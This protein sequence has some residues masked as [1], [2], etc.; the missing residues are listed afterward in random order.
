MIAFSGKSTHAV[1]ERPAEAH[2]VPIRILVVEDH[3]FHRMLASCLFE[4]LGCEVRFAC[5]GLEGVATASACRFDL[6]IMDRHMPLCGGDRATQLIRASCSGSRRAVV[7]CYSTDPPSGKLA[8]LYDQVLAKPLTT[9]TALALLAI[10]SAG[11][12]PV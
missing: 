11:S 12:R 3:P 5:D 10:V 4:A 2:P 8:A 7:V 6:V 1:D 9:E